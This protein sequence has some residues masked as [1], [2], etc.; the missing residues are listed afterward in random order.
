MRLFSRLL[1]GPAL[2]CSASCAPPV[3]QV[4]PI[5]AYPPP[6]FGRSC[7]ELAAARANLTRKLIFASLY[8]DAQYRADQATTLGIPTPLGSPFEENRE[9]EL[10]LLK[11]QLVQVDNKIQERHCDASST[12]AY[13]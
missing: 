3:S 6:D 4:G 8:Q 5:F 12:G 7:E 13:K 9:F 11:G 1:L 2:L 10:G